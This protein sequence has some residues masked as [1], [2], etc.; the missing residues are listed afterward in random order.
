MAEHRRECGSGVKREPEGELVARRRE[1]LRAGH[2]P[3]EGRRHLLHRG[4]S[5][6][7]GS[8]GRG[9]SVLVREA[10][11]VDTEHGEGVPQ[12]ES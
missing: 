9:L 8:L 1:E 4:V 6:A 11:R 3:A 5:V 7:A 10:A 12:P 2:K